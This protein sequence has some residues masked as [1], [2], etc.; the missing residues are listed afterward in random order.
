MEKVN[1]FIIG[2][3][4]CAT[5]TFHYLLKQHPQIYMS[6]IKETNYFAK[7]DNKEIDYNDYFKY[8]KNEKIIGEVSPIYSETH[9]VPYCPERIYNYNP[10]AKILYIIREPIDR[11]KSVWK[12]NLSTGHWARKVYKENFNIDNIPKMSRDYKEAFF[13]YPSFIEASKYWYQIQQYRK[14]FKDKQIKVILYED[15]K[16]SPKNIL[17]D[18]ATFLE[19]DP[20]VLEQHNLHYNTGKDKK[21]VRKYFS[22]IFYNKFSSFLIKKISFSVKMKSYLKK[23]IF[24]GIEE[25]IVID[26]FTENKIKNV[27]SDDIEEIFN[28][29]N[30]YSKEKKQKYWS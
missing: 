30:K 3:S 25:E 11:L 19:I 2:A 9:V 22:L 1:F 8:K 13:N 14:H 12:Q 16:E 18:I 21:V 27:L 10:N 28:Y 17:D 23:I 5:T 7:K 29:I 15:F 6:D 26:K 24:R 4:K 20:F